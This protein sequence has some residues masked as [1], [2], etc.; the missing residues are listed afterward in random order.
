VL[1]L[2]AYHVKCALD[3]TKKT[4]TVSV[5]GGL[6]RCK[7]VPDVLSVESLLFGLDPEFV[8]NI[9]LAVDNPCLNVRFWFE[10]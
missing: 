8:L 6:S 10:G 4:R 5:R 3:K 2:V 1:S 7:E 9:T